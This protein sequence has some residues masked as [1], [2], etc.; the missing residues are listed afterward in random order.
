MGAVKL[1]EAYTA[2]LVA[3]GY[4]LLTESRDRKGPIFELMANEN[5]LPEAAQVLAGGSAGPHVSNERVF[6]G[7]L[8]VVV[9]AI[10]LG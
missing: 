7:D 1:Q 8:C 4:Q 3:E 6:F 2:A 10:G 9:A 5:G